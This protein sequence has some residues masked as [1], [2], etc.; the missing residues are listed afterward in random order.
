MC[1]SETIFELLFLD[2]FP[3]LVNGE[4]V[5]SRVGLNSIKPALASL[6]EIPGLYYHMFSINLGGFCCCY[7]LNRV[8]LIQ[9]AH[10]GKKGADNEKKVCPK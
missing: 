7:S 3:Y 5:S 6:E 1:T 10:D 2:T 4:T 8:C 9:K